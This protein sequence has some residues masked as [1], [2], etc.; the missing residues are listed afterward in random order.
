MTSSQ[1][2]NP[3]TPFLEGEGF[4]VL[5]G[6]LATELERRGASLSD[7]LWSARLLLDQPELIRTVHESYFA[8]GADVATTASYQAS[9]PGLAARG[10]DK[11]QAR[12]LIGLSVRLACD[13]RD[14]VWDGEAVRAGPTRRVKP[15]VAG[16]VGPYGASL[17]DGSEYRG[18]YRLSPAALAD[19]HLPRLEALIEAGVD[20]LAIETAPAPDEVEVVL[21]LL[22]RWPDRAAWVSFSSEDGRRVGRR[23][24]SLADAAAMAVHPQVVAVGVNCLHP[25]Q[26]PAALAELSRRTAKPLVAYPNSG[27]AWDAAARCW[28][29]T[30]AFS[31]VG[32]AEWFDAGARLIGGCCRTTPDTIR[33]VRRVLAAR[34]RGGCRVERSR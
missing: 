19:F 5:D 24:P 17:A 4:V 31:P 14:R 9:M 28:T 12:G 8:A 6:G 3:L 29:G 18:G 30:P 15:L 32:V 13:A 20:L 2:S 27:E 10:Q 11:R 1:P 21:R 25:A 22:E 16:S 26:V 23:G 7:P 33:E 34:A